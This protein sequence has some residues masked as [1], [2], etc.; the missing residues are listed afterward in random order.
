MVYQKWSTELESGIPEIDTLQREITRSANALYDA[1]AEG[2]PFGE[3]LS[4]LLIRL[5]RLVSYVEGIE[6]ALRQRHGTPQDWA[7]PSCR[8]LFS[9]RIYALVCQ[10]SGPTREMEALQ[11]VADWIAYHQAWGLGAWRQRLGN[12]SQL[13]LGTSRQGRLQ[14][15]TG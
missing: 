14:C 9:A 4:D 6:I 15:E 11:L 5:D 12:L 13:G 8:E 3:R 2:V 10:R 7:R 1:L